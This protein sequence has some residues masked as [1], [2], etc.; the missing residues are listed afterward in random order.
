M[1]V[2]PPCRRGFLLAA[3][4]SSLSGLAVI[5]KGLERFGRSVGKFLPE[6]VTDELLDV[7]EL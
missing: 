5:G 2:I 4:R 1:E 6:R 3:L 7:G